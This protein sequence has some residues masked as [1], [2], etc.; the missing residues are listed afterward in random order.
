MDKDF[1]EQVLQVKFT[2]L[3]DHLPEAEV[4]DRILNGGEL[5]S[6]RWQRYQDG[7]PLELIGVLL[8]IYQCSGCRKRQYIEA[9]YLRCSRCL[10][11][12]YCGRECQTNHWMEHKKVCHE[13]LSELGGIMNK[14]VKVLLDD[15]ILLDILRPAMFSI[16]DNISH[17]DAA[18]IISQLSWE[19]ALDPVQ[20]EK[21]IKK[22][23]LPSNLE[24]K[25]SPQRYKLTHSEGSPVVPKLRITLK[26]SNFNLSRLLVL[27]VNMEPL[28]PRSENS[29]RQ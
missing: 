5:I 15:A 27:V 21:M 24:I 6:V 14:L 16:L 8:Q 11:T 13:E 19:T 23:T 10:T 12:Y 28:R 26:G 25:R 1:F 3:R 4:H 22:R 20:A 9:P 29:H 2:R 18:G 7:E 17:N